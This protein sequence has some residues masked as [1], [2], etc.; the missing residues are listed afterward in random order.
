MLAFASQAAAQS[1]VV[2]GA[3]GGCKADDHT[4]Q[5][6]RLTAEMLTGPKLYCTLDGRERIDAVALMFDVQ[7]SAKGEDKTWSDQILVGFFAEEAMLVWQSDNS[8]V[9]LRRCAPGS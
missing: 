9:M 1:D 6:V 7:C 3:N 4:P 5:A 8:R 2:Y